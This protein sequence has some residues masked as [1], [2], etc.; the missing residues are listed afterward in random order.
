M[1]TLLPD[2]TEKA[3]VP[4]VLHVPFRLGRPMGE[5]FDYETRREVVK[6]LLEVSSMPSGTCKKFKEPTGSDFNQ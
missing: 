1:V 4:R 3:K 6:Q 5:P 2:V